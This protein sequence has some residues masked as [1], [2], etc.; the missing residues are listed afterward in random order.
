MLIGCPDNQTSSISQ[1]TA[2]V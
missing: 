2:R 1:T